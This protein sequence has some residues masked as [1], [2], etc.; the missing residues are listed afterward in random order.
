MI[1]ECEGYE[2]ERQ[3]L[4]QVVR[5]EIGGGI[6]DDWHDNEWKGMCVLLSISDLPNG[7]LIEAVKETLEKVW[8]IRKLLDHAR[9][10]VL[11]NNH[12]Y[13]RVQK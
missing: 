2:R 6:F 3:V 5:A 1:V 11:V 13:G 10:N 12:Q 9:L 7:Q 4:I 8:N